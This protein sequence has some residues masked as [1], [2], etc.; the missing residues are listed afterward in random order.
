MQTC[1]SLLLVACI[2]SLLLTQTQL[3]VHCAL[4]DDECKE[5]E[6]K[7][8]KA[9]VRKSNCAQVGSCVDLAP[10]AG[11]CTGRDNQPPKMREP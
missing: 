11:H 5:E 3:L 1:H 8:H 4:E 7:H 9:E 6:K 2:L 10:G